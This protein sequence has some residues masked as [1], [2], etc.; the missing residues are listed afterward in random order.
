[1]LDLA[2]TAAFEDVDETDEIALDVSVGVGKGVADTGL[3]SKVDDDFKFV[4]LE[5]TSQERKIGQISFNN[6]QLD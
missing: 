2:M 4:L 5:Q 6:L 1:M 3:S